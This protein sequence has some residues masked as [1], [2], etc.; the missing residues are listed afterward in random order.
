MGHYRANVRDLEFNLFEML[1][2]QPLLDAGTGETWIP[3]P[4][5]RSS[6]RPH[7]LPKARV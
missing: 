2:L 5:K 3:R 7:N 1:N 6:P 4:F